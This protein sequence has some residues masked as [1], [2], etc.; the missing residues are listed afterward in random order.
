MRSHSWRRREKR[1]E[2]RSS[3]THPLSRCSQQRGERALIAAAHATL[4][5]HGGV[6]HRKRIRQRTEWRGEKRE[7][8]SGDAGVADGSEEQHMPSTA[9]LPSMTIENGESACNW[10]RT[11]EGRQVHTCATQRTGGNRGKRIKERAQRTRKEKE[12]L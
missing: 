9:T 3:A 5:D 8:V 7:M 12:K 1:G 4:G 6:D 11:K 2:R 10:D